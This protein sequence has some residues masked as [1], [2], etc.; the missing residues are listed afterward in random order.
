MRPMTIDYSH[1]RRHGIVGRLIHVRIADMRNDIELTRQ[2]LISIRERDNLKPAPVILH[3]YE[4]VLVMRH[5]KRLYDDEMIEGNVVD[6]LGMEAPMVFVTDMTTVGHSFLEALEDEQIW[7]RLKTALSPEEL[8]QVP[9]RTLAKIAWD[10]AEK[11]LRDK[12]GL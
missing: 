2:I 7:E 6:G 1:W 12:L 5:V 9:L 3:D 4:P 10:L 11:K 8:A